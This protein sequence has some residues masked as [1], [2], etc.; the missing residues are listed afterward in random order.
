MTKYY[1]GRIFTLNNINNLTLK[2]DTTNMILNSSSKEFIDR[3]NKLDSLVRNELDLFFTKNNENIKDIKLIIKKMFNDLKI[4]VNDS[5][6]IIY[7]VY[8]DEF[9]ELYG[10]ELITGLIFPIFKKNLDIEIDKF[11][12]KVF[13]LPEI[14]IRDAYK[15]SNNSREY[16][17][18]NIFYNDLLEN[19][20][21]N[22]YSVFENNGNLF[23]KLHENDIIKINQ[24]KGYEANVNLNISHALIGATKKTFINHEK[25]ASYDELI[26]YKNKYRNKI[27]QKKFINKLV[28]L[29]E[30][31]VFKHTLSDNYDEKLLNMYSTNENN[32]NVINYIKEL[33]DKALEYL[34]KNKRFYLS[35]FDIDRLVELYQDNDINANYNIGILYTI[36]LINMI[37]NNK[38]IYLDNSYIL[39][40]LTYIKIFLNRLKR[41]GLINDLEI[42]VFKN[43]SLDSIVKSLIKIKK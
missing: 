6:E 3:F 2:I 42:S 18:N 37:Y 33:S 24:K 20:H 8:Q 29:N 4:N 5:D 19:S 28:E 17:L 15:V 36:V 13:Y 34:H 14:S 22:N 9:G 35:I 11:V 32:F 7:S 25:M 40:Y 16:F 1:K 38:E 12:P 10:K 23:L 26:N 31:N 27:I 21:D 43:I 39:N 41:Y 30:L